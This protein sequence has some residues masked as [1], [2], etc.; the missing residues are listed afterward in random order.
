VAVGVG[1]TV[2]VAVGVGVI[3]VAVGVGVGV[4][5]AVD[6]GLGVGVTVGVAVGVDVGV[7]VAV[8]V[9]VGVAEHCCKAPIKLPNGLGSFSTGTVATTVL[10]EVSMTETLLLR[11]LAA[12]ARVPSGVIATP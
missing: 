9:G 1:V 7:D 3:G 10:V 12:Y 2:G 8:A 6:V 11:A 5:V 4:A